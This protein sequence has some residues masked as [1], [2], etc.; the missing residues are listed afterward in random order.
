MKHLVNEILHIL[1]HNSDVIMGAIA[2]KITSLAIVYSTVYSDAVQRKHQSFM[3]L[4]CVRGIHRSPLNFRTNGQW[5]GRCLHLMT[6]SCHMILFTLL[7]H[8]I[9]NFYS[10]PGYCCT[11]FLPSVGCRS[12]SDQPG[13]VK[14]YMCL[15]LWVHLK[16]LLWNLKFGQNTGRCVHISTIFS[17]G[18]SHYRDH[19]T[20][21]SL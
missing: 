12:Y 7:T 15:L 8:L 9:V 4:A 19:M 5:R 20:I 17:C 18:D 13:W 21:L 6:S 3:S 14:V 10:G 1:Y 16:Q 11:I 2:S